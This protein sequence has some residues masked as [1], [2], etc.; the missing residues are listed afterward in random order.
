[1]A[2]ASTGAAYVYDPAMSGHVLRE[3]HP[4]RPVRLNYTFEL[5]QGYGVFAHPGVQLVQ[6]REAALDELRTFHTDPY[7]TA[8]QA[9]SQGERAPGG[10]FGFS[11]SGDNPIYPGMYEAA[12]LSTGASVQAAELVADG[13]VRAAFA[14]AGGLHHAMAGFASGFCIFNDPVIAINALRKRGLRVVYVDIDA[15]H[16]DGVQA[17]F[18][19][20]KDVMTISVHESGRW[21]FPGTGSVYELGEDA[22]YG[23][24]VNLPLYPYTDDQVYLEAFDAVVPPLIKAFAPDVLATQLGT[25]AYMTDPLTHL[26]LTTN[27]YMAAVERLGSMGY[28]WLAFGGGGYDLD[29]VPRCWTLAFGYMSGKDLPDDLPPGSQRFLRSK[30]LRDSA[31]P[32]DAVVQEQARQY[33]EEQV[34]ELQRLL[35]PAHGI[36]SGGGVSF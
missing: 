22:G 33:A 26:G 28:P 36:S 32:A 4:M 15:H 8:V 13:A 2:E 31:S 18:Y 10:M 5:L 27:G 19:R 6:P 12:L 14:P 1:M 29:A 16:G 24:A 7:I 11:E 3:G 34:A 25:D 9:L 17:A 23:Y 20:D 35:F 21:L 30:Q